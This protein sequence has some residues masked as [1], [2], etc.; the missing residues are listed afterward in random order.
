MAESGLYR[1]VAASLSSPLSYR[2][3]SPSML[4]REVDMVLSE[5]GHDRGWT[6]IASGKAVRKR[7]RD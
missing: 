4:L 2:L 6:R 5:W 3:E 7:R 1:L